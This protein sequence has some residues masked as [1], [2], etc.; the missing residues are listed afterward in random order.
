M[1]LIVN[2]YMALD[3]INHAEYVLVE[4]QAEDEWWIMSSCDTYSEAVEKLN[5]IIKAFD[6]LYEL[7]D[8]RECGS[9]YHIIDRT[10]KI[11]L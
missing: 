9:E 10:G 11:L 5:E 8:N 6:R 1:E 7:C 4:V 2:D 3:L